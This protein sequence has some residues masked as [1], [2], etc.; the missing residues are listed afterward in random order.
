MENNSNPYRASQASTGPNEPKPGR[1]HLNWALLGYFIL[2][3]LIICLGKYL[4][5]R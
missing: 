4:R 1:P 2:V 3:V 5:S